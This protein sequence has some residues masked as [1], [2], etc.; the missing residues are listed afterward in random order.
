MCSFFSSVLRKKCITCSYNVVE[1]LDICCYSQKCINIIIIMLLLINVKGFF[2][3]P[4]CWILKSL[5]WQLNKKPILTFILFAERYDW[6]RITCISARQRKYIRYN[7]KNFFLYADCAMTTSHSVL[8]S[9]IYI[10]L[11]NFIFS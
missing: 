3:L 10:M 9:I 7:G 8:P 2:L 6:G 5:Y 1:T 11:F 4:R